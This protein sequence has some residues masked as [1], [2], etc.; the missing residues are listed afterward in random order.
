M[1]ELMYNTDSYIRE[2]EGKVAAI[3]RSMFDKKDCLVIETDRT[4]FFPEEGGQE[5]DTGIM[6]INFPGGEDFAFRI[7]HAEIKD[8]TILHYAEISESRR[9]CAIGS[10]AAINFIK[11]KL[12]EED[13]LLLTSDVYSSSDV[14]VYGRID[15]GERYD[16]MQQH[17]G[18]HIV[19]GVVHKKF[20]YNNV[21]FHLGADVVTMDYD[22]TFT[23]EELVE[24][25]RQANEAVFDNAKCIVTYPGED[26]LKSIEYRSK[27]ELNGQVRIVEF[28]GWDVCAC[29]APHVR[30]TGEIGMIKIMASEH[31]KG[32]TRM[33]L[34]CGQRAVKEFN[35]YIGRSREISRLISAKIDEIDAGTKKLFEDY[36]KASS[37]IIGLQSELLKQKADAE[38][39][40]AEMKTESKE[41]ETREN[42]VEKNRFLFVAPMNV[43]VIRDTVNYMISKIEGICGIFYGDDEKGYGFIIASEKVNCNDIMKM[44]KDRLNAK[45]G[46]KPGMIQGSV[47]ASK[48]EILEAV[49]WS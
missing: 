21:G 4:C 39:M 35:A 28:E 13:I 30:R 14:V 18:E 37:D 45:G 41:D 48:Q 32:G 17:S 25:E 33:Y 24:V 20:G 15:W 34:S 47:E 23:D 38:I 44:L 49:V 22:G 1:T 12:T 16:K 10:S 2:F 46:G 42:S 7:F 3:K 31:W 27:K 6:M 26:E 29:C 9:M 19:S 5:S 11:N 36:R 43:N 8:G 40:A